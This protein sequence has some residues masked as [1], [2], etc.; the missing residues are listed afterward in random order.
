MTM[1]RLVSD[2]R[3]SIIAGAKCH[4]RFCV[5][6]STRIILSKG[7]IISVTD[8]SLLCTKKISEVEIGRKT[9]L[10]YLPT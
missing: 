7:S 9:Y 4:G 2:L 8:E 5:E 1:T 10:T 6:E 3:S